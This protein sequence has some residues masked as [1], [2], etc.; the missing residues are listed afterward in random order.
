M[1]CAPISAG[2]A[3]ARCGLAQVP[4]CLY[5]Q[6]HQR[7][8]PC[9]CCSKHGA[10]MRAGVGVGTD[11]TLFSS[12]M[13]ARC[14]A[15]CA[16]C[17][18]DP[19][20]CSGKASRSGTA[21]CSGTV[22]YCGTVSHCGTVTTVERWV[23]RRH[24]IPLRHGMPQRHGIPRRHGIA[25]RHGISQRTRLPSS[26]RQGAGRSV[27][28]RRRGGV[29]WSVG[30]RPAGRYGA[31]GQGWAF[32]AESNVLSPVGVWFGLTPQQTKQLRDHLEGRGMRQPRCAPSPRGFASDRISWEGSHNSISGARRNY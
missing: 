24:G 15:L 31:R 14:P 5:R 12:I 1:R 20:P 25:Q 17:P 16:C 10:H 26:A 9:R 23:P 3:R 21:S 18:S 4:P 11:N 7:Q 22:S 29:M 27:P 6:C 13:C 8:R 30:L 19:A 28:P 32:R 2:G